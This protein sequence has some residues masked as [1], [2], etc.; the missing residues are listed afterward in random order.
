MAGI[1]L[2]IIAVA[3]I[4]SAHHADVDEARVLS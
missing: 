1:A 3:F 2:S 4:P